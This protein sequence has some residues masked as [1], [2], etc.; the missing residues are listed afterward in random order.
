M[1]KILFISSCTIRGKK[2][3]CTNNM[4]WGWL[5]GRTQERA[6]SIFEGY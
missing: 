5:A 2:Y 4:I 3:I 6:Q 1:I